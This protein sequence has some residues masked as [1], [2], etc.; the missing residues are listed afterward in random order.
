MNELEILQLVFIWLLSYIGLVSI[1]SP[2]SSN[3]RPT[4]DPPTATKNK[5]KFSRNEPQR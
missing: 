5:T 4:Y 3:K 1:F 2:K